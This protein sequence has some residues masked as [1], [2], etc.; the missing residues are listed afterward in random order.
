MKL[1]FMF[2]C[3]LIV[4]LTFGVSCG[5]AQKAGN[6]RVESGP[7][8]MALIPASTFEMGTEE[9]KLQELLKKYKTDRKQLF[10]VEM[11]KH[12]VTLDSYYFDKYE[13]TNKEFRQ[14]VE[15]NS[16]W[17]KGRLPEK[18][19]TGK[20]LDH[21]DG[22]NYPEGEGDFPVI[23]INWYSAMAYCK[24]LGKR[25][26][27][28][29]EWEYA[30]RGNLK[31]KEYPWGNDLDTTKANYGASKLERTTKVGSYPANGYGIYDTSGNVWEYL[32]DA[33]SEYDSRAKTNPVAG[34]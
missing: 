20:Y 4:G 10:T 22:L 12:T 16:K 5:L 14:F 15:K 28:E 17:E 33:W 13:V 11:P 21:W 2:W 29:A 19:D 27:T 31:G 26:P 34:G 23:N 7:K 3:T 8:R 30:A 18:F 24:W 25:L 32:A 9:A 1:R 6:E